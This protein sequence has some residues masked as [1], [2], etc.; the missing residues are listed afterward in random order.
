MLFLW[1]V[2][3]V[4]I[5]M[6]ACNGL[7]LEKGTIGIPT[8]LQYH[9]HDYYQFKRLQQIYDNNI[10]PVIQDQIQYDG[11]THQV[12]ARNKLDPLRRNSSGSKVNSLILEIHK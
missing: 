4:Q 12:Y 1:Y 7:S 6:H 3:G 5:P 9:V 2:A 10:F 8:I 11:K